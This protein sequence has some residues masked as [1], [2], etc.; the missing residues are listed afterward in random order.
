MKNDG[1]EEERIISFLKKAD[2]RMP[3]KGLCRK[4]GFSNATFYRWCAKFGG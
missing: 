2:A 1:Y 3:I 4:G